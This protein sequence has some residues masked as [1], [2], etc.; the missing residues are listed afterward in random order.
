MLL[1]CFIVTLLLTG[2]IFAACLEDRGPLLADWCPQGHVE[3]FSDC[4][5]Y[6]EGQKQFKEILDGFSTS[7]EKV[8]YYLEEGPQYS[9]AVLGNLDDDEIATATTVIFPTLNL[10]ASPLLKDV[11]VTLI[12]RLCSKNA[13]DYLWRYSHA[14][15][16][17]DPLSAGVAFKS[18]AKIERDNP[19]AKILKDRAEKDWEEGIDK[20]FSEEI[21]SEK[22]ILEILSNVGDKNTLSKLQRRQDEVAI[23]IKDGA[24]GYGEEE[25]LL[26]VASKKIVDE[27]KK[28]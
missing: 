24:K 28:E 20:G 23:K 7:E 16:D 2:N 25:K 4:P 18:L 19:G 17:S 27:L 15:L 22:N 10:D 5:G 13:V 12:S 11:A 3:T 21:F 8:R 1:S 14:V 9:M 6:V 26:E